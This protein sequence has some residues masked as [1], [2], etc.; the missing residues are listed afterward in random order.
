[1]IENLRETFSV[2]IF[3]PQNTLDQRLIIHYIYCCRGLLCLTLWSWLVFRISRLQQ[4]FRL[5]F[6]WD[7]FPSLQFLLD[8]L[9]VRL[10]V[11]LIAS[12]IVIFI[13]HFI[14]LN[15][16]LT[17][18]FYFIILLICIYVHLCARPSFKRLLDVCESH[19]WITKSV[20][21]WIS[22]A[23]CQQQKIFEH[24]IFNV[25]M[26]LKNCLPSTRMC[27]YM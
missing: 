1:M 26:L 5:L 14:L 20:T 18:R 24:D 7:R 9:I 13:A 16:V 10:I 12:L 21:I 11:S 8:R 4:M 6:T 3:Y 23:T 2:Q 22:F 17:R 25:S 27:I 19:F 15:F